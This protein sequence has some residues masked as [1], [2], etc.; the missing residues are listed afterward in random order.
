MLKTRK[1]VWVLFLAFFFLSTSTGGA[2]EIKE[3]VSTSPS[4][5]T[6]TNEDGTGLYH[7]VLKAVFAQYGVA[8]RHVYSKSGRAEELVRTGGADMMTCDDVA[9]PP[10]ALGRYPLY[11]NDFFVFFKKERI[12]PW[13]GAESLRDREILS[14]PTY[15]S[16]NNFSVPVKIKDI[17]TGTRALGMIILDRSDFYVDDMA[18]IKQSIKENNIPYDEKDFDIRKV[19]SRSYHPMFRVND[20]GKAVMKMYDEGIYRLHKAGK[21]RPI[22][23]KWGHAYPDFDSF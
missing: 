22:Y 3:V 21:L 2:G 20:R 4:W 8:V 5:E 15:Y 17:L 13:R 12:G 11:I 16:Q 7:E 10:L 14:Q 18:L 6:F 19:G 1:G 23:E 9:Q